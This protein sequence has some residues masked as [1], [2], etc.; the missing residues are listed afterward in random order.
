M[1]DISQSDCSF[2][3]YQQILLVVRLQV[4]EVERALPQGMDKYERGGGLNSRNG[5]KRRQ[6]RACL[7]NFLADIENRSDRP[8]DCLKTHLGTYFFCLLFTQSLHDYIISSFMDACACTFVR[9][10]EQI[11][12][13][14]HLLYLLCFASTQFSISVITHLF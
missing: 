7:D 14:V 8:L 13:S 1:V 9:S 3:C 6:M 11:I 12:P 5:L 10:A 2:I 4:K